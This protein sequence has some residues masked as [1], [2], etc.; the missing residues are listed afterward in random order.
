MARTRK[1]V[2]PNQVYIPV[3]LPLEEGGVADLEL[4]KATIRG[5]TLV[6]E[7]NNKLPSVAILHAIERG[8]VVGV[9]FVAPAL[10]EAATQEERDE[11][12][13]ALLQSDE[14]VTPE[15]VQES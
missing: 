6:I 9:T 7:F 12:D 5:G 11:R 8:E 2:K 4:G 1:E 10:Q 13:L 15:D 14:D 3:L